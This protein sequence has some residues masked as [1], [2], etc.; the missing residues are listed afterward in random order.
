MN[1][2]LLIVAFIGLVGVSAAFVFVARRPVWAAYVFLALQPIIGGIDRGK[3]V[4]LLRPSEALQF[5]LTAAVLGG[6]AVRALRGERLSVR[7]TRLDRTIVVLAALASIWPLF[8][9]F[10]RGRIPTSTDFF[11]T[12]VIWRLAALYALFRWVIKT[13]EQAR[14][15]MWTLLVSAGVLALLAVV[16]SLGIWRPGGIWTPAQSDGGSSGRGGATLN[17]AIAVGDYLSYALAVALVYLL[18]GYRPRLLVAGITGIV[19]LGIL[20]TGQ[21]SAWIAA[22]IVVVVVA[23]AEGQMTRL[24]AWMVPIGVVGAIVAGPVVAQRLAG[25]SGP[26]GLPPSWL[27]RWDNVSNFFWPMLGN[28]RWVLGVRPDSVIPAPE[29]WRDII[30]LESGYLWFFWVG[31]IPLFVG[32]LWFA[33]AAFRHTKRVIAD[34]NDDIEVAAVAARASL[35]CLMFLSIIDMH[36]TLRGGGDLFFILLGLS[37][38]LN[39][40]EPVPAPEPPRARALGGVVTRPRELVAGTSPR[41]AS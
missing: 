30:Y 2:F 31:G 4:P 24:A 15:C 34:R 5:F 39:V 22:F 25:F 29:T 23:R 1:I 37:A 33:R 3:L 10:A 27:G 12:I 36:L 32:F 26:Q 6:V 20:G 28:F 11:S 14:R 19:M 40:P 17:S 13:P 35:W 18:R 7:F 21:F 9:M 38:N 8:W 41:V 16:D